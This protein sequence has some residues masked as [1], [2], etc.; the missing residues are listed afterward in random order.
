MKCYVCENGDMRS[1]VR[2]IV[3]TYKGFETT[4]KDVHGHWCP[5]CDEF[6]MPPEEAQ[7]VSTEMLNF[8]ALINAGDGQGT[9]IAGVRKKLGLD[10][11]AAS[12]IFGGGV[13][14]FSR[15]E[16]GKTEAAPSLIMLLRLLDKH[17]DLLKEIQ[18]GS[19]LPPVMSRRREARSQV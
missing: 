9:F 10:Q 16:T 7:R 13:N 18:D 11:K 19:G 2:D 17:P 8:N 1:T 14:A 4:I 6:A 5:A 15:Y 3:H 12:R